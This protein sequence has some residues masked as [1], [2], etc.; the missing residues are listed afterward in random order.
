MYTEAASITAPP[1]GDASL[2]DR[3]RLVGRGP[4]M[5]ICEYEGIPT[6]MV[7][8]YHN[9]E[10]ISGVSVKGN[11]VVISEPQVSNSGVYQCMV[12]NTI[13]GVVIEDMRHW[14]LKVK[15]PGKWGCT[16]RV[17]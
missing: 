11:Q 1:E 14:L 4:V 12:S 17:W 13:D 9:G 16:T 8:W 5:F 2:V 7:R 3:E 15:E 10:P 6:P